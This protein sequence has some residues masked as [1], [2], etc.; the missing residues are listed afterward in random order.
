MYAKLARR[1]LKRSVKDY[2]IYVLTL[3]LVVGLFYSFLSITSPYYAKQLPISI[4]LS[5]LSQEMGKLIPGSTILLSFLIVYV[6]SYIMRRKQK[7]FALEIMIGMDRTKVGLLFFL[8]TFWMGAVAVIAGILLGVFG[9]QVISSIV[10]KSFGEPFQLRLAF[11]PDT[12]GW[13]LLFFWGLFFLVGFMNMRVLKKKHLLSM[14]S[15]VERGNSKKWDRSIQGLVIAVFLLTL[16]V[17]SLLCREMLP[18]ITRVSAKIQIYVG[19]WMVTMFLLAVCILWFLTKCYKNQ[20]SGKAEAAL[21]VAGF[22]DTGLAFACAGILEDGVKQGVLPEYW[23]ML[24]YFYGA[25]CL[26]VA[27]VLF[28][29][30]ASWLALNRI[31][32]LK[33]GKYRNLFLFGQIRSNVR[34]ISKTIGI[35]TVAMVTGLVIMGWM[36]TLSGEIEG[37]L[38]ERSVYDLQIFTVRHGVEQGKENKDIALDFSY[39]DDYLKDKQVT[40]KSGARIHSYYL[41]EEDEQEEKPILG[42]AVSDYNKLRTLSGEKAIVL[43]DNSFALQWEKKVIPKDMQDFDEKYPSVQIGN[44]RLNKMADGNYQASVGM[45]LFTGNVKAVYILPDAVCREL[46]TATDYYVANLEETLSIEKAEKI[47]EEISVWLETLSETRQGSGYIRLKTLQLNQGI[48][49]TLIQRLCT[50]YISLILII[51][52]ATIIALQQ[53]MDVAEHKKRFL[54]IKKLGADAKQM[55]QVVNRQVGLWFGISTGI[56]SI[57]SIGILTVICVKSYRNYIN[58]VPLGEVLW[59]I[60]LVYLLFWLIMMAYFVAAC[61]LFKKNIKM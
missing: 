17:E 28:Y 57:V 27:V 10:L 42:I 21:T 24:P 38:K 8:E 18:I 41:H 46:K 29:T 30:S 20:G 19:F 56:S 34:A 37:Y 22:V 54:I 15:S 36:P 1:S 39:I 5:Y 47:N 16:L 23:I 31:E 60:G 43:S 6:N 12:I 61:N 11:Y 50:T 45:G 49:N 58:Y 3:V 35:I 13:T 53:I 52:C 32:R 25:V 9:S 44:T 55:N 7:E 48:S 14:L 51:V 4:N 59:K 33:T 40:V 2:S 26:V